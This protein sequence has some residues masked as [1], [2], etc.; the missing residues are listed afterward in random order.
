MKENPSFTKAHAYRW[1]QILDETGADDSGPY[2]L[3]HRGNKVVAGCF[4]KDRNPDAPLVILAGNG[5]KIREWADNFCSQGDTIP[6]F[7]KAGS[8][9]Q[10]CGRFKLNRP[11]IDQDEIKQHSVRAGRTDVYKL[12]FLQEVD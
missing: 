2:Y 3:L 8:E 7:V 9:W 11:S 6:L 10:F 1:K 4:K 12:L 5:P